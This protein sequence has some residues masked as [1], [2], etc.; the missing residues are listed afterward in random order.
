MTNYATEIIN[1]EAGINYMPT[2]IRADKRRAA[3]V[4]TTLGSYQI[5]ELMQYGNAKGP[6]FKVEFVSLDSLSTASHVKI[7]GLENDDMNAPLYPVL[8]LQN[9]RPMID[10]YLKKFIFCDSAGVE[11]DETGNY[12]AIGYKKRAMPTVY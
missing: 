3:P 7:W 8:Y 6:I 1:V 2:F 9:W 4:P 10:V 12:L 5:G 11:I